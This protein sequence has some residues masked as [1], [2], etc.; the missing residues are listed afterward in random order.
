M[1]QLLKTGTINTESFILLGPLIGLT[2]SLS[3]A[4]IRERLAAN[5]AEAPQM[6]RGLRGGRK[7]SPPTLRQEDANL[8]PN[9]LPHQR[10]GGAVPP[11]PPGEG[12]G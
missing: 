10:M 11:L 9:P 3:M 1:A 2:S 8:T 12:Q 6:E 4:A 7:T 5:S